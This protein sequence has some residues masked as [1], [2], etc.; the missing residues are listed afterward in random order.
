MNISRSILMACA[1]E[2]WSQKYLS[3]VSGVSRT[4]ISNL[5]SGKNDCRIKTLE[6]LAAA[7]DM[8][9]SEFIALGE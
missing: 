9:V 1:H 5:V 6:D 4:T 8:K 2:G 3:S 7:F